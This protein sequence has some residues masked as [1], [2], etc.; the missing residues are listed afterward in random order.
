MR[1]GVKGT[2]RTAD[3]RLSVTYIPS[4]G[5]ESCT[6]TVDLKQFPLSIGIRWYNPA[7]GRWKTIHDGS[8]PNR[9]SQ[10]FLTPSDN[11]TQ[12]ND[13]LLVVEVR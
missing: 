5:T 1:R 3:N 9:G 6:L 2:A 13:W 11:G 7:D 10:L 12:T 8:V 4:T